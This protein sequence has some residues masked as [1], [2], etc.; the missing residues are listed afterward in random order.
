MIDL[1]IHWSIEDAEASAATF[2]RPK[3]RPKG[4]NDNDRDRA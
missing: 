3:K 4:F 1:S 2:G